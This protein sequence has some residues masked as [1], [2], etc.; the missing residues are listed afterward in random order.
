LGDSEN[1]AANLLDYVT[2]FS[3]NV[4]DIFDKY[5]ISERIAEL[6]EHDLLFHVTQR[7]AAVDLSPTAVPNEEMGHIFEELIRKFAEAS[8]ETAGEHF[9]PR[10]VIELMVDILLAPERTRQYSSA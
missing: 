7:F 5:K 2:G 3:V 1:L 8:N 10:D 9:T 6:D 4:K